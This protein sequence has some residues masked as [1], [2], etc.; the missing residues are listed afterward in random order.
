MDNPVS[1]P[2]I[3]AGVS[4]SPASARALRWAADEAKRRHGRLKVVLAWRIQQRAF[5]APA[6]APQELAARQQRARDGLAA[7]VRAV[8]GPEQAAEVSTEITE[9]NPERALVDSSAGA[10]LLVLGAASGQL[11]GRSIGPV[12]RTCLS[13]AHCP[14]VVVGPEGQGL[15]GRD[16]GDLANLVADGSD[17]WNLAAA[18]VVPAPRVGD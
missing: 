13:R 2:T 16:P 6:P 4:G 15:P 5:Y 9:G 11:A 8:L 10:D 1:S 3:V 17:D 14:V 18:G 7:T 12:V